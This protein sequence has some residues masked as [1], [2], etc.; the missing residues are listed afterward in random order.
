MT[1]DSKIFVGLRSTRK[2][3]VQHREASGPKCQ[4][5]GCE[6]QG[7]HRA[8]VGADAEGLYLFFCAKHVSEYGRGYNFVTK[9]SAPITAR[10]QREAANGSRPTWGTRIDDVAETR[11]P[12]SVRSGTAKV[13]NARKNAAKRQAAK[14][15]LNQRKLKV[16]EAKAFETLGLSE[17]ATP[18]EIKSRYKERLKVHHPDANQGDRASEEHLRAA[19][20]AHKILK[21]NGFC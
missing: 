15:D 19:I 18:E 20:D 11:L 3:P 6:A 4:W 1:F 5:E 7:T 9:L 17:D 21:L 14:A 13:V 8:P 12:S 16:L 10:Y 2:S